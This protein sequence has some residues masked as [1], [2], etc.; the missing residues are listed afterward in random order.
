MSRSSSSR[1][2][3]TAVRLL[4]LGFLVGV[5][6]C[7]SAFSY[8]QEDYAARDAAALAARA[9]G[10]GAGPNGEAAREA[11]LVNIGSSLKR[12]ANYS[13]IPS[14]QALLY[15]DAI[16]LAHIDFTKFDYEGLASFVDDIVDKG[17]GSVQSDDPYS[18]DLREYQK[19]SLKSSFRK[20][21]STI[22]NAVVQK[23]FANS[24]D[25]LYF[26]NYESDDPQLMGARI[27][28]MPLEGLTSA[29]Q[30][31]ALDK[32]CDAFNAP[33]AF[34]RFGFA[35][36]VINHD[37]EV[38]T[39]VEQIKARYRAK[40]AEQQ[41][42]QSYGA[43]GSPFSN[44]SRSGAFDGFRAHSFDARSNS[45]QLAPVQALDNDL[46]LPAD[47][48][49]EYSKEIRDARRNSNRETR[50]LIMPRIR[51]RFKEPASAEE[52]AVLMKPLRQTNG[53]AF[54]I[55]AKSVDNIVSSIDDATSA[56]QNSGS[57]FAG[58]GAPS[59]SDAESSVSFND[60]L[61]AFLDEDENVV[62][63]LEPKGVKAVALAGSLVGSPRFF[64]FYDFDTEENAKSSSAS[65]KKAIP[66]VKAAAQLALVNKIKEKFGDFD[67]N[68]FDLTP[69][70]NDVFEEISPQ[71]TDTKMVMIFDLEPLRKHA[72]IFMPLLG[73]V[74]S[75]SRKEME[76]D[77][78]D[79]DLGKP[80]ESA[81]EDE[82]IK[83]DED[84]PYFDGANDD[85]ND[86][87]DEEE[88]EDD[89]FFEE[90]EDGDLDF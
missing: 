9:A 45:N 2:C 66:V 11:T 22:Q 68:V 62:N 17:A 60:R 36:A 70:V 47:L 32:L 87:D 48:Y 88:E 34:I 16:S 58:L 31:N 28:A 7:I 55:V 21:L 90:E 51:N 33:T 14:V 57:A 46:G 84:D 89:S 86:D 8:A 71:T 44:S 78:I 42:L 75:K 77:T 24:I 1:S 5:F 61:N 82:Q 4:G 56:T 26:I 67:E 80:V 25:E 18:V 72:A 64:I 79:W 63:S 19:K 49:R 76:A 20:L 15:G 54:A 59:A 27:V 10:G 40:L 41:S 69:L 30:N 74:E 39:N 38:Q 37:A 85:Q 53:A 83:P 81:E 35:I 29:E 23:A 6:S 12:P 43:Y 13:S 50:R 3:E 73:G 65:L 52:S